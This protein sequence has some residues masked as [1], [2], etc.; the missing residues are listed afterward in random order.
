[1]LNNYSKDSSPIFVATV[2][3][4]DDQKE[5]VT[6]LGWG[7]RCKIAMHPFTSSSVEISDEELEYAIILATNSDG[8]GA[9]DRRR[10]SRIRQGDTVIG[11]KIGGKRGVAC[12][13]GAFPRTKN[14]VFDPGRFGA[15]SG[16]FGNDQSKGLFGSKQEF[17][18]CAGHETPGT[19]P[20]CTNKD[21]TVPAKKKEDLFS[22]FGLGGVENTLGQ[23]AK[24]A[25][26]LI[27]QGIAAGANA[28]VP[29]SGA[30]A[31]AAFNLLG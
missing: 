23:F 9:A 1:M 10:S 2:V 25:K 31:S 30:I 29:G 15:K 28:L 26:P 3:S 27:S 13:L 21:K 17:S 4:F 5:Q 22:K 8:T 14:T 19:T 16:R 20:R 11:L 18:E 12:I 24:P 6:G 7:W